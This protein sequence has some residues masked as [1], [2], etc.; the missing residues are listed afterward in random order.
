MRVR[1]WIGLL[2]SCSEYRSRGGFQTSQDERL[3]IFEDRHSARDPKQ[4]SVGP[5]I[6]ILYLH[7]VNTKPRAAR[8][9]VQTAEN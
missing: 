4:V 8:E 3:A 9:D 6:A 5:F 7:A 1:L 2:F